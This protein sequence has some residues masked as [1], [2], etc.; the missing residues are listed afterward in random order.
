MEVIISKYHSYKQMKSEDYENLF[1][2]LTEQVKSYVGE[3]LINTL[4]FNFSTSNKIT[5]IVGYTSIM[6]AMKKYFH[7]WLLEELWFFR[8]ELL[9]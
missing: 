7:W 6:S 8:K 4:D 9:V 2:K 1:E 5:K 3:E